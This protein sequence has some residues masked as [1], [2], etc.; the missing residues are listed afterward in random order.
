MG[1]IAIVFD[2]A[3]GTGDI[4]MDGPSLLLGNDLQTAVLISWFSD[5][6]ASPDDNLPPNFVGGDPRG[7]WADTYAALEDTTLAPIQGDFTGS[8]LWQATLRPRNQ[9]TLNWAQNEGRL[10]LAWMITDNVATTIDV[11]AQFVG[12]AGIGLIATITEP[13]GNVSR[14]AYAWTQEG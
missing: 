13:S 5:A 9:D 7:W 12:Q 8:K 3:T 4:A 1:D 2:N 10:R 6:P 14:Y 11:T